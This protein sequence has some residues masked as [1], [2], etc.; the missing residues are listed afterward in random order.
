MG[1]RSCL[2]AALRVGVLG[3]TITLV[4][5]GAA[6]PCLGAEPEPLTATFRHRRW[7]TENGLPQ[8]FVKSIAQTP[9]GALWIGTGTALARFDGTEFEVFDRTS[10]PL[11]SIDIVRLQADRRGALWIWTPGGTAVWSEQ[12][13]QL[14]STPVELD[15]AGGGLVL[16]TSSDLWLLGGPRIWRREGEAWVVVFDRPGAGATPQQTA[17][18]TLAVFPWAEG[19]LHGWRLDRSDPPVPLRTEGGR[20]VDSD[21]PI[22]LDRHLLWVADGKVLNRYW[23]DRQSLE[24][25]ALDPLVLPS[26]PYTLLQGRSGEL[27]IGTFAGL[28]R[29]SGDR[30]SGDL[31]FSE[32]IT[33][34]IAD[35]RIR[36][37][38]E[39]REGS[40]WV[41]TDGHGLI[42][43]YGPTKFGVLSADQGLPHDVV[44]AVAE[45]P[46]HDLWVGTQRGLARVQGRRV[47]EL[48]PSIF[49]HQVVGS[50]AVGQNEDMWVAGEIG[51]FQVPIDVKRPPRLVAEMLGIRGRILVTPSG[52]WFGGEGSLHQLHPIP[53]AS[54]ATFPFPN[55]KPRIR[56]LHLDSQGTLWVATL[57][58]GL[59]RHRAGEWIPFSAEGLPSHISSFLETEDGSI[60]IATRERGILRFKNDEFVELTPEHGLFDA[61]IHHIVDDGVGFFWMSSDRGPFK[62][63]KKA[64]D[65][66]A[67]GLESTFE[68]EFFG[69]GDGLRSVECNSGFE[70]VL[71]LQDE[72]LAFATMGGVAFTDPVHPPKVEAPPGIEIVDLA[73]GY[74]HRRPRSPMVLGPDER[75]I[76]VKF[77]AITLVA[78]DKATFRYR[79]EGYDAAW[80]A[81]QEGQTV[82]YTDLP[83]GEYTFRVRAANTDGVW[84]E[85]DA[86]LELVLQAHWYQSPWMGFGLGSGGC[87]L[88][89]WWYRKRR[90]QSVDAGSAAG[91]DP[92]LEVR[93]PL[94]APRVAT[95]EVEAEAAD[96]VFLRRLQEAVEAN[97]ASQSFGVFELAEQLAVSERHLRRKLL[98]L[99]GESPSALIRRFRME[100]ARQLLQQSAG[101]V[102]EVAAAVGFSHP[103]HFS[104]LYR[105]TYGRPPSA[106]LRERGADSD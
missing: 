7:T 1:G 84:S 75:D 13:F 58:A 30:L 66:V 105:K 55:S 28:Y 9:D 12:G 80:K 47:E 20:A 27:W 51:L 4:C 36:S 44:W 42:Q 52:V 19:S 3:C 99:T 45:D 57:G 79:L 95:S 101:N 50:L 46:H 33:L 81:G 53:G 14:I 26:A 5:L 74:D 17:S 100:R 61:T 98:I 92:T 60:W 48:H 88:L 25:K 18:D 62:V 23:I 71:Q 67:E 40:L 91:S 85:Q 49:G 41:G 102:S 87:L 8:N 106:D 10:S 32:Q 37:L 94:A 96:A 93:S 15:V 2:E 54:I 70:G 97:L 69:A 78:P 76:A 16:E 89:W 64:L 21:G 38:F 39:D 73:V 43:V 72:R 63:E 65:L 86:V 31:A 11:P 24:L 83:P 104:K 90:V 35:S 59:W 103:S 82:Y 34:E 22:L 29:L 6:E 68:S 56:D 77:R